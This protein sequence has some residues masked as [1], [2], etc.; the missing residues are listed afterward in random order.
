MRSPTLHAAVW[1][2]LIAAAL[3]VTGPEMGPAAPW[4]RRLEAVGGDKAV[5]ALLFLVQAWLVARILPAPRTVRWLACAAGLALAYGGLTEGVQLVVPGRSAE[6]SD[7]VADGVGA[8]LGA[9]A[10]GLSGRES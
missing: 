9:V 3:L 2:I 1:S 5:H 6:L 4:I 10:A 8:V 7:L